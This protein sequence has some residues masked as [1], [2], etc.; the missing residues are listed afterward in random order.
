MIIDLPLFQRICQRVESVGREFRRNPEQFLSESD[1]QFRLLQAIN[2]ILGRRSFCFPQPIKTL[3]AHGCPPFL[4][5]E[6]RLAI[7]PDIAVFDIRSLRFTGGGQLQPVVGRKGFDYSGSAILLEL[8]LFHMP[9]PSRDTMK[10]KCMKDIRNLHK[11]RTLYEE[12]PEQFF[13]AIV[14]FSKRQLPSGLKEELERESGEL[15]FYNFVAPAPA[16]A[17]DGIRSFD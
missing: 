1:M 4:N 6:G 2:G 8:K 11:I 5:R 12:T 14:V 16:S 15:K 7:R 10:R 13:G 9:Y 17:P 3:H